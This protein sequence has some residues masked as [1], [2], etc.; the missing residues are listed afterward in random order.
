MTRRYLF[1]CPDRRSASGGIDV[2]YQCVATL[3]REGYDASVLHG[4]PGA[5]Y[6][7]ASETVPLVYSFAHRRAG[8]RHE[9]P[10]ALVKHL[11]SILRDALRGGKLPRYVPRPKDV[12]VV[13]EF[14]IDTAMEAY[15]DQPLIV[16]VQNPF[17]FQRAFDRALARGLDVRKRAAWYLSVS[18]VC[19][20]R[21]DLLQIT[22]Y[23]AL[24]VS[25]HPEV[26]PFREAK[27][28]LITYMP[29]KRREEGALI[30]SALRA[31]GHIGDYAL[32]AL[33]GM[34][35]DAISRRLQESRF[36]ISLQ[37]H[38]SIGFP[39]AEAM[40]AG[41]VVVGYTGLGGREYFD[42]TTGIPVTEDD[43]YGVVAALEAAIAEYEAD[44]TRLDALRTHASQEINRRYSGEAFERAL[45][46]IWANLPDKL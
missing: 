13:P 39:A 26:F 11:V 6:P 40:A 34:P 9:R 29:R 27:Q 15:P 35:R 20:R 22:G 38:E 33:D 16:F 45:L 1:L 36:F 42:E 8:L 25:M 4:G 24:P 2:I 28:R 31:R 3:C 43:T 21:L 37:K 14:M 19:E 46:D 12:I 23:S 41:C 32:E 44:P 7:G 18:E 30:D 5:G 10:R 17:S